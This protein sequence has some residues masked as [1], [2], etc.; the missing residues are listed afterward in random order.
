MRMGTESL[1]GHQNSGASTRVLAEWAESGSPGEDCELACE[2]NRP[3]ITG[4]FRMEQPSRGN[5]QSRSS[6]EAAGGG[7]APPTVSRRLTAQRAAEPRENV[8]NSRGH[9]GSVRSQAR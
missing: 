4:I 6:G 8:T 9:A 7:E 5:V 2:P 1:L 3:H